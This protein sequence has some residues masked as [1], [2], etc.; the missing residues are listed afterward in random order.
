MRTSYPTLIMWQSTSIKD[1]VY[2]WDPACAGR[3]SV[4]YCIML[5][6]DSYIKTIRLAQQYYNFSLIFYMLLYNK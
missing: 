2:I 5:H 4:Y 6:C 1:P 3:I